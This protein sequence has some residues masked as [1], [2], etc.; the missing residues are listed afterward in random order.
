MHKGVRYSP[1]R[2]QTSRWHQS[3][4]F[5]W[6][7]APLSVVAVLAVLSFG[8]AQLLQQKI[9]P[10]IHIGPVDVGGLAVAQAEAAIEQYVSDYAQQPITIRYGEEAW[11][12]R[13]SDL[14]LSVD[15]TQTVAQAFHTG[16]TS[17]LGKWFVPPVHAGSDN[18]VLA[19]VVIH[20]PELDAYLSWLAEQLDQAPLQPTLVHHGGDLQFRGGKTGN[21]LDQDLLKA[22]LL[23]QAIRLDE[24]D[25]S[26]A[27]VAAE[28]MQDTAILQPLAEQAA[29]LLSAPL[30][31]VSE[32]EEFE[33]TE[34][35]VLPWLTVS[36]DEDGWH[37]A[38]LS[39][40]AKK[41]FATRLA[42]LRQEPVSEKRYESVA[43]TK[44]I[45]EG[46]DGREV[47]I[48]RLITF[49]DAQWIGQGENEITIPFHTIAKSTEYLEVSAPRN[50]GK[51]IY[52]DLDKQTM[53]AFQD[54]VL[55]YYTL[56][57]SGRP[58]TPTIPGEYK[59]Y[60]KVRRQVMSGPGYYLPNVEW[61]MYYNGD[62]GI[63]SA[64]WHNNFGHPMSHGCSNLPTDAAQWMYE[65]AEV[66]TPVIIV[67]DT[68]RS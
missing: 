67:G 57:S 42:T 39:E 68:P 51:L 22:Q 12:P 16:R 14:G 61:V 8:Y 27:F 2:E 33:M 4:I 3:R 63:H 5:L 13:F 1:S 59:V 64:Y 15:I 24:T 54:G 28:A 31:L 36:E 41:F 26:V 10:G 9:Y 6:L 17:L 29:D 20:E 40:T 23:Q 37:L 52:T 53:F 32:D 45:S 35:D 62:Y 25:I 50:E 46:K 30:R 58:A 48:D 43:E 19:S 11:T 49:L 65:F 56:I 66:G 47:D 38:V 44:P 34:D 55:Q 18:E 21:V 7:S 60:T